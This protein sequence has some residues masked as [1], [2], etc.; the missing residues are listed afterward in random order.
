MCTKVI[1][2]V[3]DKVGTMAVPIDVNVLTQLLAPTNVDTCKYPVGQY[4]Y[5]VVH[6]VYSSTAKDKVGMMAV[7]IDVNVLTQNECIKGFNMLVSGISDKSVTS[8]FCCSFV[9]VHNLVRRYNQI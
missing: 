7:P 2:T 6:C 5:S 9:V 1:S 3:K 8:L 4:I